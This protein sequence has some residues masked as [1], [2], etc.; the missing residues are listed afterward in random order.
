MT[1]SQ[2]TTI[3][4]I[5]GIP[6]INAGDDVARLV[7]KHVAQQCPELL[8]RSLVTV[9]S[10]LFSKAHGRRKRLDEVRPTSSAFAISE[11][12][13]HTPELTQLILDEACSVSRVAPGVLIVRHTLGFVSANAGIDASNVGESGTVL[14]LPCDPDADARAT[15][16]ALRDATGRD[17]AVVVTDSHGRPF[18][19]GTIG[20]AIGTAGFA[21]IRSQI[22]EHDRDGREMRATVSA[23]AD[24]LAAAADFFAGQGDEGTPVVVFSG[25]NLPPADDETTSTTLYR[26][27]ESDIFA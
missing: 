10:K 24:Q 6:E 12:S 9:S 4:T 18:R 5:R 16:D 23:T 15:R 7:A 2:P 21:P 1:V 27:P 25:I 11:R 3:T 13:G 8:D 22:G 19:T 26:N 17:L 14:L 20:V